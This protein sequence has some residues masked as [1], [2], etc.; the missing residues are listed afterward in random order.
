MSGNRRARSMKSARWPSPIWA[1]IRGCCYR[2][3]SLPSSYAPHVARRN[4]ICLLFA[5]AQASK[6]AMSDALFGIRR[7]LLGDARAAK[8]KITFFKY[9]RQLVLISTAKMR[10]SLR[11]VCHR[12]SAAW[13]LRPE[14]VPL[15]PAA[16][17][18]APRDERRWPMAM[19]GRLARTYTGQPAS[20]CLPTGVDA[21]YAADSL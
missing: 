19:R 5:L 8:A 16:A 17:I 20:K 13:C 11:R 6:P 18:R 21:T 12:S 1:T 7:A 9:R 2:S 10:I 3:L 14:S 15:S 4:I